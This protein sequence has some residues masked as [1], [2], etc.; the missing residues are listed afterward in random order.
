M[1]GDAADSFSKIAMAAHI[2]PSYN[3][4]MN[5]VQLKPTTETSEAED[6]F[7]PDVADDIGNQYFSLKDTSNYFPVLTLKEQYMP[8]G[9]GKPYC[10]H[11]EWI[12]HSERAR[13]DRYFHVQ[14]LPEC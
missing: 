13:L 4:E 9:T 6:S 14:G 8:Y 1:S 5:L 7:S 2:M 3:T 12:R 10:L 11:L